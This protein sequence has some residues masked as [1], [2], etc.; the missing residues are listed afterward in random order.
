[1]TN[2]DLKQNKKPQKQIHFWRFFVGGQCPGT[3]LIQHC[4]LYTSDA[5]DE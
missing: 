5:A 2:N 1:M 4:L 3:L